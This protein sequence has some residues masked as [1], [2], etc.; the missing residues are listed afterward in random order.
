VK[1]HRHTGALQCIK[2]MEHRKVAR[3]SRVRGKNRIGEVLAV[4]WTR[5]ACDALVT[6]V[7]IKSGF[8]ALMKTTFSKGAQQAHPPLW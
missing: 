6:C 7:V 5:H 8:H 2:M 1:T 3:S 4:P